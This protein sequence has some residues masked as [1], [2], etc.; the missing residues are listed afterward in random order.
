LQG[1]IAIISKNLAKVVKWFGSFQIIVSVIA[2]M[3]G[4]L[5]L[6]SQYPSI[7]GLFWAQLSVLMV[8]WRLS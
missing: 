2:I 7:R 5:N 4:N 8:K 3:L 1:I 6:I